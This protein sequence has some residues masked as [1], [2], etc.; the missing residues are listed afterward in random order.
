MPRLEGSHLQPDNGQRAELLPA[1]LDLRDTRLDLH[2][3]G[4]FDFYAACRTGAGQKPVANAAT[5]P[6]KRGKFKGF[7]NETQA[8]A[9]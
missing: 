2:G 7:S 8:E 5:L 9:A 4:A 6:V 3:H 1:V